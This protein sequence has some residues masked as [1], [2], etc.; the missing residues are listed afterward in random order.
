MEPLKN[1]IYQHFKGDYYLVLE[2]AKDSESDREY[3]VYRC[4][5]GDG[6]VYVREKNMFL[7]DVDHVK[8]PNAKQKKRFALCEI[9]SVQD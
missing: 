3:V 5:Y 6:D 8:Y 9:E 7:S 1:R 4:L 2:I